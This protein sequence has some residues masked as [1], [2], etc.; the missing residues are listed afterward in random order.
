MGFFD[1]DETQAPGV[2]RGA[3]SGAPPAGWRP[4]A[5]SKDF[6]EAKLAESRTRQRDAVSDR[7]G[8]GE[9]RSGGGGGAWLP[10]MI[11]D[12]RVAGNCKAGDSKL[13]IETRP[14]PGK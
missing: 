7:A 8:E 4:S 1:A 10:F 5:S 11:T 9:Q 13:F 12:A 2:Q 14:T 6:L 3:K